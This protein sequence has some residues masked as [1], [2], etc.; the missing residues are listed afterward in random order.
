MLSRFGACLICRRRKLRCD[1]TQPECNRCRATGNTCQYQ[2]PAYTSRTRVLQGHIREL[3]A[4]I[5]QIKLQR[6]EGCGSSPTSISPSRSGSNVGSGTLSPQS[7]HFASPASTFDSPAHQ[8]M[9]LSSLALRASPESNMLS[10]RGPAAISLPREASRKLLSTFMQRKQICGFAL[11]T[12]RVVRSFQPGSCEPTAPALYYAMILFG[13]HFSLETELKFWEGMFYERTKLEIEANITRAHLNDRIKYNTLHHLQAMVLLGQWYYFKGRLLEGHVYIARAVRFAVALG[14][15]ELKSRIYGHYV[16]MSHEPSRRGVGLWK[17]RD[18]VELGEAINLWW[19]CFT[20][21]FAGTL[22]NGLPPSISLEEIK[23]VWP[24]SLSEFEGMRG[25][26]LSNDSHSAAALLDLKHLRAVADVS[27]DTP[28]CLLA[29]GVMLVYCAGMLDTERISSSEATEEWLVRFEA[30]DRATK[31]FM[32]SAQEAYVGRDIEEVATIAMAQ[33]AVDCAAI[34]LHSPL[35]DYELDVGAQDGSRGLVSDSSLGGY[36][37]A[38]CMESSKSIARTAAYTE[39]VDTSYMHTFLG[40]SWSC[41]ASLLA[42][43]IPKLRRIGYTE[44]AQEIEQHIAIILR[45]MERLLLT[46]PVLILQ[47]EQLRAL[48]R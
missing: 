4:K 46:Y 12:G 16:V 18:P 34:Q 42:T 13:C 47:V 3:E 28:L 8:T 11:H 40:V 24:V 39:G 26:E 7:V 19:T 29:K 22:V 15:H 43:Q 30:C 44:Q 6:G 37:Y 20:R 10:R 45:S 48:L 25:S 35:A 9:D 1:A 33:A 32:E 2:D 27:R 41:A 14:L 17:P 23:T 38:R 21:D 36:S 31:T 5:D